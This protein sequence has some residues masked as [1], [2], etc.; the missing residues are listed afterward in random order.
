MFLDFWR[1]PEEPETLKLLLKLWQAIGERRKTARWD[2]GDAPDSFHC[3]CFTS[4][5]GSCEQQ[6]GE[7]LARPGGRACSVGGIEPL[8]PELQLRV[9]AR[10]SEPSWLLLP[11]NEKNRVGAERISC[12]HACESVFSVFTPVVINVDR[13]RRVDVSEAREETSSEANTG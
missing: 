11:G 8:G 10:P 1:N 7:R 4:H 2:Q 13:C 3:L 12:F 5:V 9:Q 6:T